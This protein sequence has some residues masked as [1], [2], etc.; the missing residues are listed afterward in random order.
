MLFRA[1]FSL[2][3]IHFVI[4]WL[5]LLFQTVIFFI[6]NSTHHKQSKK[7]ARMSAFF[8]AGFVKKYDSG[9]IKPLFHARHGILLSRAPKPSSAS[10]HGQDRLHSQIHRQRWRLDC[11]REVR[12]A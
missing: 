9:A 6:E 2:L 1:A 4:A 11:F 5:I 10:S 3:K 12:Q 8:M 7:G